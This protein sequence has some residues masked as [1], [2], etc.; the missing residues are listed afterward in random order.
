M[1][2]NQPFKARLFMRGDLE[3]G[4]EKIRADSPTASKETLK[5]ALI[6]AANEGFKVKTVDIKSAFLEGKSLERQIYVSPPAEANRVG[7]LWLLKQAAYGILDGGR[8]FYLKLSETLESLGLHKVHA[9]GALFTFVKD[10]KLHG[11]VASHVD[12]LLIAGDD[13]FKQEVEEKLKEIFVFSKIEENS[14]KYCGCRINAK[15]DGTIEIDQ[16]EYVDVIDKISEVEG[17]IDRLLTEKEKKEVRTKIGELLWISLMTRPDLSYDVNVLSSEVSR[18]TVS[19]V[20]E[21]NRL[22]SKAKKHKDN[23]LKFSKLGKISDLKVKVF[24]DASYGN[25]DNGTRST[26]GRIVLLRNA[27]KDVVNIASWKTKKISCVCRSVKAA[28]TRALEDAIDDGVN[29]ARVFKEIYTGKINLR[30]PDQI[31]VEAVTDSKSLWESIHNSRQC[32][33]KMLR[34]CIANIKEMKQLGFV[35]DI[36]WVPTHK[37]LADSMTKT[38][39]KADWLLNVASSNKL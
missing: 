10:G 27:D 6:V 21:L 2:K 14:F 8:K 39:K 17:P 38:N 13:V 32:E 23:V 37:Q 18:A 24:A 31:P 30:N 3:K 16:K 5:L 33:E 35:R 19:T 15:E 26:E 29:T 25:R 34:T 22:I 28:E 12:D 36:A 9:D 11:L 20:M 1:N 4:K 7:K